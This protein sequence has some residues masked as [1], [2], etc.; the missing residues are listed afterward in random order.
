MKRATDQGSS[1]SQAMPEHSCLI[2]A[3]TGTHTFHNELISYFL[4]HE[5][6]QNC[7]ILTDYTPLT[8]G[9]QS[10]G[11][12]APTRL[13]IFDCQGMG[14]LEC[15]EFLRVKAEVFP[16]GDIV[17]LTGV[18]PHSGIDRDALHQGIRGVFYTHDSI[19]S[20]KKGIETI[21]A[22]EIW[23]PRKILNDFF[24]SRR[25]ENRSTP[26]RT[27]LTQ[28]EQEILALITIGSTNN[29]IADKLNISPYTVKTHIYNI[30]KKI[31]TPN[32]LQAAL[33]AID[34]L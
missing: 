16:D 20:F 26:Q 24:L 18:D 25:E 27:H 6:N 28:K 19:D 10:R 2:G 8:T 11:T 13:T 15:R 22:G 14:P 3:K 9:A 32:R 7:T 17:V 29:E 30:F 31:E 1:Q 12:P 4:L 33:W 5:F 21:L 23:F 34:N